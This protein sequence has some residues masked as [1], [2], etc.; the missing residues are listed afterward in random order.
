LIAPDD[1]R[2]IQEAA[3]AL[4]ER[5]EDALAEPVVVPLAEQERSAEPLKRLTIDVPESKHHALRR[6]ALDERTTVAALLR[7]MVDERLARTKAA[8]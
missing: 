7:E 2:S 3:L 1:L 6:L 4:V 8:A 5:I